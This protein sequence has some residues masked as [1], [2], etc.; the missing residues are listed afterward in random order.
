MLG[1]AICCVDA[2][3]LLY[4]GAGFGFL[5]W[6]LV[7]ANSVAWN[8]YIWGLCPVVILFKIFTLGWSL[9]YGIAASGLFA[10]VFSFDVRL[11][12]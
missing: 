12:G 3:G 9:L 6:L 4:F 11:V 5:I 1:V 7:V 10:F 2:F 8:F